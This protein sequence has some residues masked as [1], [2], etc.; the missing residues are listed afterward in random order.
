MIKQLN[1]TVTLFALFLSLG[2]FAQTTPLRVWSGE[3]PNKYFLTYVNDLE[4]PVTVE[5]YNQYHERLYRDVSS[6]EEILSKAFNL[7]RLEPGSYTFRLKNDG[8]VYET[9]LAHRYSPVP[10]PEFALEMAG[11][12]RYRLVLEPAKSARHLRI[13]DDSNNLLF[14]QEV[15]ANESYR[16]IYDLGLVPSRKVNFVLTNN[17][18][19]F[20]TQKISLR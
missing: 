4:G 13:Y 17:D 12:D 7:S 18:G 2:A 20:A 16:K 9:E 8:K 19:A 14:E 5:I 10:D 11:D 1:L 15:N 3:E 6:G